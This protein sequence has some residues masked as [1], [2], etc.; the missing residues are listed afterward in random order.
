MI[1]GYV[2]V[3]KAKNKPYF[4]V[5]YSQDPEK[6]RKKLQQNTPFKLIEWKRIKGNTKDEG[7]IHKLL[8]NNYPSKIKNTRGEWYEIVGSS[9]FQAKETVKEV[10]LK[11]EEMEIMRKYKEFSSMEEFE[12]LI[13]KLK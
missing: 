1:G 8:K 6:R 2:Y 5:G 11:F 3:F 7:K 4:K 9:E 12:R 10:M 13:V